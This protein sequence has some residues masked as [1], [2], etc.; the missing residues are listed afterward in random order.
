M[1]ADS[2]PPRHPGAP[3]IPENY[4]SQHPQRRRASKLLAVVTATLLATGAGLVTALPAQ[5]ASGDVSGATLDW[6]VKASWR[7]YITGPIAAGTVV[8]AN[9]AAVTGDGYTWGTS[10]SGVYNPSTGVGEVDFPGSVRWTGHDGQL[11]VT[12]ANPTLV[13]D[14]DG[15]GSLVV[16][17]S[18]APGDPSGRDAIAELAVSASGDSPVAI[19]AGTATLTAAGVAAFGDFYPAGTELDGLAASIPFEA[20]PVQQATSTS[21]VVSPATSTEGAA[22]SLTATVAPAAAGAIEFFDGTTSL[23]SASAD[24]GSATISATALAIGSHSLTARFTPNDEAAFAG[25]T[26]SAIGH[27]VTAATSGSTATTTTLAAPEA[28]P[29]AV[30]TRSVLTATVTGASGTPTGSVE[31]RGTRAGSTTESLIGTAPVN[32]GTATLSA[33]LGAGATAVR[34]VFVPAAGFASSA[35]DTQTF[36]IVDTAVAEVCSPSGDTATTD[37]A[38]IEWDWSATSVGSDGAPGWTK[39]ASGDIAVDGSTFVFSNGEVTADAECATIAFDGSFTIHPYAFID[40]PN[41]FTLTDP[42]L[43]ISSSGTGSW[44]ADMTSNADATPERVTFAMFDGVSAVPAAGEAGQVSLP[45]A[46]ADAVAPGTWAGAYTDSWPTAFLL[47]VPAALRAHFYRSSDSAAQANKPPAVAALSFSWPEAAVTPQP[48]PGGDSDTDP[49]SDND[50]GDDDADGAPV[51]I[52]AAEP[53]A[54]QDQCTASSVSGAVIEWGVKQSF[55]S[56]ITGAIANGSVEFSGVSDNGGDYRWAG[57]TGTYN[58]EAGIGQVGF[59][60]SVRFTGHDGQL[61]LTISDLRVRLTGSDSGSLI[62]D[63][64]SESLNGA[65][66]DASGI[67]LA[68]L[69]LPAAD[70]TS[71]SVGWSGATATLTSAGAQAFGGFYEAGTALDAVSFSFPLGSEVACDS[72]TDSELASTGAPAEL[73]MVIALALLVTGAAVVLIRRRRVSTEA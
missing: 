2:A 73:A 51:T 43:T 26:S 59:D 71:S 6:G 35:S 12:F 10:T 60:G 13:L 21:L 5:A 24:A 46:Y 47:E 4:V 55:R 72:Y 48:Q 40:D 1:S 54:E 19:S 49:N 62:A 15:T 44:T 70:E 7:S 9:G 25:S 37:D 33:T 63:V 30:G 23:G 3:S 20:A 42:V 18:G 8:A 16:D 22:V 58:V 29:V 32:S 31:F 14:G 53:Q 52:P 27:E 38:T 68:T 56:Y 28:G 45:F 66:V 11:D 67:T 61:D 36:R 39:T 17:W 65:D 69:R 34:A 57:G 50:S 41:L 64:R